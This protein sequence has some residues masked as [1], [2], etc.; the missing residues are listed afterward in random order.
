MIDNE[1]FIDNTTAVAD[2]YSKS[3]THIEAY[4]NATIKKKLQ[5]ETVSIGGSNKT[6]ASILA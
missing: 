2:A 5:T 3:L 1:A 6:Y 4:L